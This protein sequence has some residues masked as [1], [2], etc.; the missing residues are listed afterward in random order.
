MRADG[1]PNLNSKAL[2]DFR[3]EHG[4]AQELSSAH[5]S[6]SNGLCESAVKIVQDLIHKS[7]E[8]KSS[9]MRMLSY[10]NNTPRRSGYTPAELYWGGVR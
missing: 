1:A 3:I 4:I 8:E 5:F 9:L 10:F 2:E 7:R 6:E